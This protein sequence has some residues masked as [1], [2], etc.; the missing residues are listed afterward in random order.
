MKDWHRCIIDILKEYGND[1]IAKGKL[2]KV[3]TAGKP[4]FIPHT[5][6]KNVPPIKYDPD[7][8]YIYRKNV[9]SSNIGNIF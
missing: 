3:V 9:M 5:D 7:V 4:I 8:Y 6:D 2:N 1:L